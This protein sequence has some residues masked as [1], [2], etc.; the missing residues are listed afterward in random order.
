M[1]KCLFCGQENDD[2]ALFCY[3][4]GN[5][6]T[7]ATDTPLVITDKSEQLSVLS[8]SENDQY[9]NNEST[10]IDKE[11]KKSRKG[12]AIILSVIVVVLMVGVVGAVLIEG[13]YI[14]LPESGGDIHS[15]DYYEYEDNYNNIEEYNNI[16]TYDSNVDEQTEPDNYEAYGETNSTEEDVPDELYAYKEGL[17]KVDRNY[18]VQLSHDDWYINIRS[19]PDFINIEQSQNNIVGKMQS[20]TKVFVYYIYDG[21]WIV[22]NYDGSYAFASIYEKNDS[23]LGKLIFEVD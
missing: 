4:C 22:F 3:Y 14:T 6:I 10:K 23:S 2:E 8:E 20:G 12:L 18:K 16:N 21:K 9:S 7:K 13:G 5:R 11:K 17:I 1:T 19:S 15:G